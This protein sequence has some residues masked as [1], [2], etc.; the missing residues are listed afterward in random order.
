MLMGGLMAKQSEFASH[1]ELLRSTLLVGAL[2]RE[3]HL[4]DVGEDTTRG[5]GDVGQELV[6]LLVVADGEL[7]VAGD[8]ASALV[9]ARSIAGKLE[10]L[11]HEVLKDGGEVHGGTS[12]N[13]LSIAALAEVTVDTTDGELETGAERARVRV[14][15]LLGLTTTATLGLLLSSG[16]SVRHD[17]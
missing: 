17:V 12:T 16:L 6:Q 8:D 11:S 4:V 7:D 2:S 14:T 9:V 10:D 3:E 5:D 1:L 15:A 13:A